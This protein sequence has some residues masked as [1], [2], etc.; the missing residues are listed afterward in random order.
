MTDA[1]IP[2]PDNL[3]DATPTEGLRVVTEETV[4]EIAAHGDVEQP[5]A[6]KI[7]IL[8]DVELRVDVIL[9]RARRTLQDLLSIRPSQTIELDR[10]KNSPVEILVNNRAFALG[11]IVVIDETNL[12]VRVLEILDGAIPTTGRGQ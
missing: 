12:G 9:G 8:G 4:P 1:A 10:Q 11:E 5:L 3:E 6:P 7:A 2:E